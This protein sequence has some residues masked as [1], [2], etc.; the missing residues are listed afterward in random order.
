MTNKK[1]NHSL[2]WIMVVSIGLSMLVFVGIFFSIVQAGMS[3][4]LLQSENEYLNKQLEVVIG[5]IDSSLGTLRVMTMDVAYWDESAD[6]LQGNNPTYFNN[7]AGTTVLENN[8]FDL[9][10]INDIKGTEIYSEYLNADG[11]Q[12][13]LPEGLP[14]YL[15]HESRR[16]LERFIALRPKNE[17]D[18]AIEIGRASCRERV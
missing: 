18:P 3:K 4:M 15:L 16:V 9:I 2:R 11:V 10:S 7:W 12:A 13:Q 14:E 5:M 17:F 8:D 1:K 6:Y